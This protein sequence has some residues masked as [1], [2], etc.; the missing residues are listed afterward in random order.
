[1]SET[2]VYGLTGGIACGKSTIADFFRELGAVI[3]DADQISRD[4]VTPGTKGYTQVCD[5]FGA[6][7]LDSN[8]ELDRSKLGAL[9]FADKAVR[10]RLES[11]M[12]PLISE[13]SLRRIHAAKTARTPLIVYEAA[14]LVEAGRASDF[15]P[16]IVVWCSPDQQIKRIMARDGIS[17]V[18]AQQ[19]LDSQMPV[20][21]KIEYADIVIENTG[22][23]DSLKGAVT[24]IW[25]DVTRNEQ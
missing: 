21:E 11:I 10:K 13:E 15:R 19:R 22:D 5:A 24:N 25:S 18:A 8:K 20:L 3:I 9:V 4:V 16:L 6:D 2:I 17:D 7:I 23:Q 12:H 14:L 1:M